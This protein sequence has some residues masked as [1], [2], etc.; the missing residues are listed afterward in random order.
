M[1]STPRTERTLPSRA[2]SPSQ[3]APGG[4]SRRRLAL[5]IAAAMARSKELPSLGS[6]AGARLTVTFWSG[7]LSPLLTMAIF[8]RSRASW[9]ERSASPTM[10]KPGRPCRGGSWPRRPPERRPAP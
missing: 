2:S 1:A 8:T 7:K 6:W 4:S 10:W 5:M 3:A 9:S